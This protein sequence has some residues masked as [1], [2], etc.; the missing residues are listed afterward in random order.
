ME[1][2]QKRGNKIYLQKVGTIDEIENRNYTLKFD[3]L[4]KT[5]FLVEQPDFSIPSQLY[6]DVSEKAQLV[7]GRYSNYEKNLG[8]LLSGIKGT[9]KSLLAKTICAKSNLPV[10]QIGNPYSSESIAE[11]LNDA[12]DKPCILFIDEIDKVY[13]AK[14]DKSKLLTILDGLQCKHPCLFLMTC[15]NMNSL[16][17]CM[18]NRPGRCHYLFEYNSLPHDVSEQYIEQNL[19]HEEFKSQVRQFSHLYYPLSID[20]LKAIVEEINFQKKGLE[21]VLDVL[22]ISIQQT[23]IKYKVYLHDKTTKENCISSIK[24]NP[25][26]QEATVLLFQLEKLDKQELEYYFTHRTSK[27][28]GFN[29]IYHLNEESIQKWTKENPEKRNLFHL[30]VDRNYNSKEMCFFKRLEFDPR[31]YELKTEKDRLIYE[32]NQYTV[33]MEKE[34][35]VNFY[36]KMDKK[37]QNKNCFNNRGNSD[38]HIYD[39]DEYIDYDDDDYE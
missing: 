18:L 1:K 13:G 19:K 37:N 28:D 36:S 3:D 32:N 34:P 8:V 16:H 25:L 20:I 21:S 12:I 11:I 35:I 29:Q 22:N 33:T 5:F 31:E 30:H 38:V 7:L 15:N 17:D 24:F 14:E 27:N 23:Q 4:M 10:I 39:G 26:I 6:G 2:L 9:G